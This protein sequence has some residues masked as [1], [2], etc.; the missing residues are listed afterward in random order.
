MELQLAAAVKPLRIEFQRSRKVRI[1][2]FRG[3]YKTIEA[4]GR[5]RPS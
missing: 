5:F 1:S 2:F 4:R 3:S